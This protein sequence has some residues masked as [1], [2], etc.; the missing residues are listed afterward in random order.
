LLEKSGL[1][2]PIVAKALQG[3]AAPPTNQRTVADLRA[4]FGV[5][6]E[7]LTPELEPA[8]VYD[9]RVEKKQ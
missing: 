4:Q 7:R 2:L 9:L 8:I 1:T 6:M 5:M 3:R